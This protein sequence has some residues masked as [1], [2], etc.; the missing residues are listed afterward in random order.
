MAAGLEIRCLIAGYDSVG[1]RESFY[2]LLSAL[3]Q[4]GGWSD[5]QNET[6][7]C[8]RGG[9]SLRRPNYVEQGWD[10]ERSE[11]SVLLPAHQ[12]Q[13][14]HAQAGRTGHRAVIGGRQPASLT[15]VNLIGVALTQIGV[16][17]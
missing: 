4:S 3:L 5:G 17:A 10:T 12:R 2:S 13:V 1:A 7:R 16:P 8:A 9:P 14:R 15:R 11:A 6:P